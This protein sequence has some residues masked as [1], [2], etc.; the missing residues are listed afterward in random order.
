M[1]PLGRALGDGIDGGASRTPRTVDLSGKS[2]ETDGNPD[3]GR[4]FGHRTD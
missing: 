4:G 1:Q 3:E 2:D